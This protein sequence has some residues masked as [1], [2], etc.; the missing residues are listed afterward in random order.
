MGYTAMSSSVF[1]L[2]AGTFLTL[3]IHPPFYRSD[4]IFTALAAEVGLYPIKG[5]P[6]NFPS[7]RPGGRPQ[8]VFE[9]APAEGRHEGFRFLAPSYGPLRDE[10][11]QGRISRLYAGFVFRKVRREWGEGEVWGGG[12]S[13]MFLCVV[14]WMQRLLGLGLII[15]VAQEAGRLAAP[16]RPPPPLPTRAPE[17]AA[18]APTRTAASAASGTAAPTSA[19][20]APVEAAAGAVS[21]KRS[22]SDAAAMPSQQ[23]TDPG[24]DGAPP[25]K[26]DVR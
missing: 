2:L 4:S 1:C 14:R 5:M 15:L 9:E 10:Q 17:R 13:G 18:P 20:P 6:W 16:P 22:A 23:S 19:A 21:S 3:C 11:E 26:R 7:M 24:S 12:G 8:L 25:A